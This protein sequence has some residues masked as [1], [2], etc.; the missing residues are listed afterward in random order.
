[1]VLWSSHLA[2]LEQTLPKTVKN[3]F[4]L[5]LITVNC[6]KNRKILKLFLE[7]VKPYK[8]QNPQKLQILTYFRL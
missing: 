1:M 7:T 5:L 6:F 4:F 2:H 8:P 3:L